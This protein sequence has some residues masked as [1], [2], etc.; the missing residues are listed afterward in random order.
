MV[1]DPNAAWSAATAL[2]TKRA[3]WI[4][5]FRSDATRQYS[6]GPVSSASRTTHEWLEDP[7]VGLYQR[8]DP[9]TGIYD[10]GLVTLRM[11]DKGQGVTD[12]FAVRKA[13][14]ILVSL[15]NEPVDVLIGYRERADGTAMPESEYAVVPGGVVAGLEYEAG[16][17]T[18]KLGDPKRETIEEIFRNA[19]AAND[20][21]LETTLTNSPAAGT[22]LLQLANATGIA[23]DQKLMIGKNGSAQEERVTVFDIKPN[24]VI[25]KA[26]LQFAYVAGQAVRWATT[27]LHGNPMN[28]IYSIL[29]GTFSLSGSF[30]LLMFDGV[31]TG[32]DMATAD[33][34]SAGM[35]VERDNWIPT[36]IMKFEVRRP[37]RA[38]RWLEEQFLALFGSIVIKPDGKIGFRLHRPRTPTESVLKIT[39]DETIGP[40]RVRRRLDLAVNRLVVRYDYDVDRDIFLTERVFED[41]ALQATVGIREHVL[42]LRGGLSFAQGGGSAADSVIEAMAKRY[43]ERHKYG[44]TEIVLHTFFK[45]RV[46][47]LGE[48]CDVDLLD[49]PNV[50]TGTLGITHSEIVPAKPG[51]SFQVVSVREERDDFEIALM[52][53]A[54]ERPAFIAL[55][56]QSD[57]GSATEGHRRR[58]YVAPSGGTFADGTIQYRII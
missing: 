43:L 41:T 19:D 4:I 36:L 31:P 42:E 39:D 35:I 12:L 50:R 11:I 7:P 51:P 38:K 28:I 21:K 5:R 2:D 48:D 23:A 13:S 52:E 10:I 17:W 14:P 53:T 1:Y 45:K 58:A 27:R 57:Y 55:S 9:K 46:A 33:I 49:I 18:I 47:E 3:I 8:F 56:G 34:D 26:P 40:S 16:E 44:S 20:T 37:E 24:N 25:L 54:F 6:T 30:P 32:L 29:T 15:Q 22:V